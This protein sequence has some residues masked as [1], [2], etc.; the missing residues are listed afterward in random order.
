MS[1]STVIIKI[2][3]DLISDEG[4]REQERVLAEVQ[5][6]IEKR[7]EPGYDWTDDE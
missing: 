6:E 5:V 4:W 3:D 2:L 7:L 1:T